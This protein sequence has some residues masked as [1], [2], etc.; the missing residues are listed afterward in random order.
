[1]SGNHCGSSGAVAGADA[2]IGFLS[3]GPAPRSEGVWGF[4]SSPPAG[5]AQKTL[6]PSPFLRL[7]TGDLEVPVTFL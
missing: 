5:E 3:R 4:S 2:A 6:T 7:K 1:M